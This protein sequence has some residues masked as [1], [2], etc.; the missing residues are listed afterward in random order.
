MKNQLFVF[1]FSG[2]L[3]MASGCAFKVDKDTEIRKNKNEALLLA[4]L[5]HQ[6]A[7][8][9]DALSYQAFNLAKKMLMEDSKRMGLSKKP[10]VVVDIDE[11]ILDN[12]P[13][14]AELILENIDYPARWDEW[15]HSASAEPLKG[16]V[17]FLTYAQEEGY[18]VFYITNRREKFRQPTLENLQKHGFPSAESAH[19]L[20]RTDESSK[21]ERRENVSRTHRIVL[22]MGDNLSDFSA[23]FDEQPGSRRSAL[24]D[25]LKNEFGFRYIVLPNTMYGAW[26]DAI[27]A[28]D[29]DLTE[30]QKLEV[31]YEHLRGF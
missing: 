7:A 13:Y 3:L 11:T 20:M 15:I 26:L 23:V 4:T 1:V 30:E 17:E 29:Y 6:Q 19:L 12:S 31:L 21:K 8:E 9:R 25:S 2:F 18:D 5:Y 14:E 22:L 27:Y 16:A 24:V 10:A 28:Y